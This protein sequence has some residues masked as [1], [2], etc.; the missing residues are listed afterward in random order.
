MGEDFNRVPGIAA[1]AGA[2]A[3]RWLP[4]FCAVFAIGMLGHMTL[5]STWATNPDGMVAGDGY[6]PSGFGEWELS[7]GRWGW[8]LAMTLR[9]W[10]A[11][12]PFIAAITIALFSVGTL[13]SARAM[14][15]RGR[16]ALVACA[17]AVTLTPMVACSVSYYS[18]ADVYGWAFLLSAAS[19]GIH[20]VTRLPRAARLALGPAM[21]A[22]SIACYQSTMGVAAG[23]AATCL[24]VRALDARWDARHVGARL[25][26][27]LFTG[28]AGAA[29]YVAVTRLWQAA[30]GVQ[31]AS[32]HG[33]D[34]IG[35]AGIASALPGAPARVLASWRDV[36]FG[37]SVFGNHFGSPA[38]AA[39]LVAL[40]ALAF[41]ALLYRFRGEP[42]RLAVAVG[43]AALAP[44]A[45]GVIRIVVPDTDLSTLMPGGFIAMAPLPCALV[46]RLRPATEAGSAH[47]GA[48]PGPA[49]RAASAAALA[50]C[51]LTAGLGWTYAIQV[52]VDAAAMR[53]VD[54][55]VISLASRIGARLEA[56][57]DVL[58]G[59][60]VLVV[61]IP[62]RG[63]Y[64]LPADA[65]PSR[66]TPYARWGLIWWNHS[67]GYWGWRSIFTHRLGMPINWCDNETYSRVVNSDEFKAMPSYPAEGSVAV[68]GGVVT[69]KV[70]GTEGFK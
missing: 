48:A 3:R 52:N 43:M 19:V 21:L 51:L 7:L 32:F 1:R 56:D 22:V 39:V 23:L 47:E 40:G 6:A 33:A 30:E 27:C 26:D 17:S 55:Q 12:P 24:L 2:V 46:C 45:A 63:S 49:V 13:L 64:P 31:M 14:G 37:S 11:P 42:W 66:V 67:V 29:L 36:L 50:A 65:D 20:F 53:E 18:F 57:P 58:A 35:L 25:A 9:G 54:N 68:V 28:A 38:F 69:V 5:W 10:A 15:V 4:L 44:F 8:K 34:T 59:A 61:G 70:S 16:A 60:P 62:D 41:A